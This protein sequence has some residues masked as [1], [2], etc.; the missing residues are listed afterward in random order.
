MGKRISMNK[1]LISETVNFINMVSKKQN[2]KIT[3]DTE[4]VDMLAEGL[5]KNF[6]RYGYYSCPCRLAKMDKEQ[7]KDIICPCKYSRSDIEEHGHCYCGLYLSHEFFESK[8][9]PKSI[10]EKRR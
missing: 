1:K 3:R 5:T 2:W 6:N 10:P 8:K 7:D 4:L 9:E